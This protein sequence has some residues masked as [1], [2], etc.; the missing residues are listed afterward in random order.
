MSV[1]VSSPGKVCPLSQPPNPPTPTFPIT[2]NA[3]RYHSALK[4]A[5]HLPG[6]VTGTISPV[7]A[8]LTAQS[9]SG[10]SL[11]LSISSSIVELR[12]GDLGGNRQTGTT[13]PHYPYA[14]RRRVPSSPLA[15]NHQ[16]EAS[17]REERPQQKEERRPWPRQEGKPTSTV[18]KTNY[19]AICLQGQRGAYK[20]LRRLREGQRRELPT[21]LVRFCFFVPCPE[22]GKWG[23][24][25]TAHGSRMWGA[26]KPNHETS[27]DELHDSMSCEKQFLP[28]NNTIIYCSEE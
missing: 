2:R 27:A 4:R 18:D 10:V 15:E 20:G 6:K 11:P 17:S 1:S 23:R 21:V 26:F 19:P 13:T 24:G 3:H 7:R 22:E 25:T 5:R 12:V 9:I 8:A 16:R 28:A 14:P